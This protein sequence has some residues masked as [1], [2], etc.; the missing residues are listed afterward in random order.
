MFAR[1]LLEEYQDVAQLVGLCDINPVRL[2]TAVEILAADVPTFTDFDTMLEQVSPDVVIV[3]SPDVTHHEYIIRSLDRGK[4]VITE[5]P[6]TIDDEK[7][8][9]ILEAERRSGRKVRVAFNYRHAPYA[10]KVKE[11]LMEGVIGDV[12]SVDF[13]WFL[14]T[15]HGADYFRRWHRQKAVSGGLMVHKATHHFDLVNWWLGD[16]PDCVYAVGQRRFYGPTRKERG[17]R[18][19]TCPYQESCEFYFDLA[20]D[21]GLRSL[22]LEAETSDGYHRDACV[23]SPEIDIE[24]T[25]SAVVAYR[26]GAQMTYSLHAYQPFEGYRIAFNGS[27]GR[28][29]AGVIERIFPDE[30][31][32]FRRRAS[33]GKRSDLYMHR[34]GS[35]EPTKDTIRVFPI[36][37]GM[38]EIDVSHDYGGHG[39]GDKRLRDMLFRPGLPDPLGH[40]AGSRAGAMSILTGVAANYSMKRNAPVRIADLLG[41]ENGP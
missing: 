36:Y 38:Q 8:R 22:Y 25:I 5:K 41:D 3:T 30:E 6:M 2:Q 34:W 7:C 23:F 28:L 13:H 24:D 39:G 27:R 18:C 33:S 37:G 29:E 4:D 11:L 20:A 17:E 35:D 10:T 31:P 16:E 1:P 26:R 12:Y 14:D 15:V 19:L 32:D 21:R 40:A 9:A